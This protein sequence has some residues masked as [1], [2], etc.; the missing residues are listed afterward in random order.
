MS[1]LL[2]LASVTQGTYI[3][4]RPLATQ[5]SLLLSASDKSPLP[6]TSR[7]AEQHRHLCLSCHT[8]FRRFHSFTNPQPICSSLLASSPLPSSASSQLP[9]SPLPPYQRLVSLR[10]SSSLRL[11]GVR[12]AL[13]GGRRSVSKCSR[14][15]SVISPSSPGSTPLAFAKTVG[16]Y[17]VQRP[18]LPASFDTT[19]CFPT[20]SLSSTILRFVSRLKFIDP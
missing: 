3:R 18:L 9:R 14:F 11:A 15:L 16:S 7:A 19:D 6:F 2:P 17:E 12:L 8:S 10:R 13:L 5:C 20:T 4:K 1:S